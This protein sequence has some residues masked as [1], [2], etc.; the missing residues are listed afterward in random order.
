MGPDA[1]KRAFADVPAPGPALDSNKQSA[2]C[3]AFSPATRDGGLR[4]VGHAMAAG[5]TSPPTHH[6]GGTRRQRNPR[7]DAGR[8][9]SSPEAR[10]WANPGKRRLRRVRPS[11]ACAMARPLQSPP[12]PVQV[13]G[14]AHLPAGS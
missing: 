5:D 13:T 4:Q 1:L 7:N 9:A 12:G 8:T 14:K 6:W 2:T 11:T 10:Q 3:A